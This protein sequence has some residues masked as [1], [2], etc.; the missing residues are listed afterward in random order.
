MSK[1][2]LIRDLEEE[3]KQWEAL[4]AR[5][6]EVRMEQ[7][8]V[9]G[10]WSIKDIVAH[11]MSWRKRTVARLQAVARGEPQPRPFWPAN[12]QSDD[13]INDWMYE[14]NRDRS[15]QEV[16]D[17]SRRVFQQLLA[18]IDALP[19]DVLMEPKSFPWLEGNSLTAAILF[20][21][22]HDE[23]EAD[24]RAWLAEQESN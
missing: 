19:G 14:T 15:V 20:S 2:E 18:A 11:L 7:P 17:D 4:L 5:I 3:N 6:G 10:H 23:H 13:E 12:L 9:A 24:M 21:H 8:G 22:F 1:S 16:L